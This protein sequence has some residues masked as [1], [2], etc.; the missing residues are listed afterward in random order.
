LDSPDLVAARQ[1]ARHI[2]SEH[3][4]IVVTEKEIEDVLD[5]V[6]YCLETPDI[7]T[8]R[9]SIVMYLIAKYIKENTNTTV[10][11]SG[12]GADEVAQGYIYYKVAPS[13]QAAYD[14]QIRLLREIYLF[15]GLRA[16]RTIST[17]G[18]ELRLP[19]LDLQFTNYYLN[20]P[21]ELIQPK[22]GDK[23]KFMLRSAFAGTN[24]L[25][26][27]ILWRHKEAF[28]DGVTSRTK[29]LFQILQ[30]I[31][32]KRMPEAFDPIL[33]KKKY[34][35]CTP[36]SKEA[37]Y[38]REMFEK[39]F[40]NCAKTFIPYYWMPRWVE[41]ITDPSARFIKHY[42]AETQTSTTIKTIA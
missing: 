34:P 4:E 6:I 15:D 7:T 31:V 12:E 1:V 20:M 29:T 8:V 28:S 13:A 11:F 42:A 25:P 19:F 23:E 40:P 41:G 3:Y 35:H 17:H 9:A 38:Y 36:T 2:D 18:L 10:L 22:D 32:E 24:V 27:N 14:D 33:A 16:D 26:E 39:N 21:K 5:E 37:Y 30:E